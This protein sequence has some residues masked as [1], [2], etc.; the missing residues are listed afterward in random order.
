LTPSLSSTVRLPFT[1]YTS[2][3]HTYDIETEPLSYPTTPLL[4]LIGSSNY[5]RRSAER[6]VEANLLITTFSPSLRKDLLAE[7]ALTRKYATD[8]VDEKLFERKDRQV[9][10][11]VKIASKVI[12][13]ML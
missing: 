4:T 5:G 9:S 2:H 3:V 6:D 10:R 8:L 1:G 11:G 7:I 13:N 12:E